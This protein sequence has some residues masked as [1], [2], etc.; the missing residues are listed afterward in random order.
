MESSE[1]QGTDR[2]QSYV[3]YFLTIAMHDRTLYLKSAN[4]LFAHFLLKFRSIGSGLVADGTGQL[5]VGGMASGN[6]FS[7]TLQ[8]VRIYSTALSDR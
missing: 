8:D 7:G 2:T 5:M 1:G 3:L 6:F 4:R